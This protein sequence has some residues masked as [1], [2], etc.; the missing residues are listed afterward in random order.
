MMISKLLGG[1]YLFRYPTGAQPNDLGMEIERFRQGKRCCST[2]QHIC[3]A[4]DVRV[5]RLLSSAGF[6][7]PVREFEVIRSEQNRHRSS[8][9][10]GTAERAASSFGP[11]A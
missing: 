2:A 8:Q 9:S 5:A 4:D 11:F 1:N 10:F 7:T 3:G 6:P